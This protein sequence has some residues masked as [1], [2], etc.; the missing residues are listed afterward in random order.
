MKTERRNTIERTDKPRLPRR[1]LPLGTLALAAGFLFGALFQAAARADLIGY[2]PFEGTGTDIS[3]NARDLNVSS[4]TAYGTGLFGE[5]LSLDGNPA[6]FAARPIDDPEFDF[7]TG[8]FTVQAWVNYNPAGGTHVLI[9]KFTGSIGPGWTFYEV[10][11]R[12]EFHGSAQAVSS[13]VLGISAGN[14]HQLIARRESGQFNLFFDNTLVG[15]GT[16]A[17]SMTSSEPLLIGKRHGGAITTSGRIDEVAIWNTALSNDEIAALWN[18]GTGKPVVSS[19]PDAG[20]SLTLSL[21]ACSGLWLLRQKS[22][23]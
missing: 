19:V 9:E 1:C 14:W 11:N 23:S 10:D 17:A 15:S 8:D 6:H 20:S 3:G 22:M 12:W 2:W 7:G 21:L 16:L 18:G 13:S 4:G 5:A